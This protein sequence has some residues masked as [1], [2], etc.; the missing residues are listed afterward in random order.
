M[1]AHTSVDLISLVMSSGSGVHDGILCSNSYRLN[2]LLILCNAG[3]LRYLA[4][5]VLPLLKCFFM[6]FY[7][8]TA[9]QWYA[10]ISKHILS[11]LQVSTMWL[12]Y[13]YGYLTEHSR[14]GN[15]LILHFFISRMMK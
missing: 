8:P 9:G 11:A 4:D 6:K 15:S 1:Q 3:N 2:K 5:G 13:R 12:F 10:G 14:T 7:K